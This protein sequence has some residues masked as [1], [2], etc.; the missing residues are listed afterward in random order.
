MERIKHIDFSGLDSIKSR[1]AVRSF[2]QLSEEVQ[3]LVID[4]AKVDFV[5]RLAAHELLVVQYNLSSK[6]IDTSF[7]NVSAQVNDML[8]LVKKSIGKEK[9]AGFRFVK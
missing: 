2:L 4:F 5:S 6:G 3:G 7:I 1:E 9:Q 8:D